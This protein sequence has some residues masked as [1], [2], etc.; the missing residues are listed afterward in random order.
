MDGDW[1]KMSQDP[2][3]SIVRLVLIA[4]L[5]PAPLV[6]PGKGDIPTCFL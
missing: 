3:Y 5:V 4:E 1:E 2:V 6:V